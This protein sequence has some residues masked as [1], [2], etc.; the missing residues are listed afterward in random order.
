MKIHLTTL[1]TALLFTVA[2]WTGSIA[3]QAQ[4]SS[5]TL[6][7]TTY[8][9]DFN[10]IGGGA[11]AG[12]AVFLHTSTSN[13]IQSFPT[14]KTVWSSTT[15]GFR[16][17][18]SA[19]IGE[20][21][22]TSEQPNAMNRALGVRQTASSY[23]PG[24]AFRFRI[25]NTSQKRNF[26]LQFYL[27]S[28]DKGSARIT[29]WQVQYSTSGSSTGWTPVAA[30]G[31]MTTGGST[32]KNT[33]ITVDFG[34]ALDDNIGNVYIEIVAPNATTGNN[35]RASSAIDNFVLTWD[36]DSAS[37]PDPFTVSLDAGSGFCA[38]SSL[39]EASAGAGV[40]LPEA[41][42]NCDGWIFAG[43]SGLP[44]S[45]TTV[46]PAGLI[47]AGAFTPISDTTLYA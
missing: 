45:E 24:A 23:D 35:N 37:P 7:G 27:Q 10:D 20:G 12:W 8:T 3:A 25:A 29:T 43:W 47:P 22:N 28:L 13:T 30:T 41:T 16:N 15:G 9:Q 14:E 26:K 2:L 1:S 17:Y 11:P 6:T 44:V 36:D 32:F 18:A 38:E 46:A 33:L 4:T 39:T 31:D 34:T 19:D 42:P 5:A 21:A 40:T